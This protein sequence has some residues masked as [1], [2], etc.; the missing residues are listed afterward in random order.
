MPD[1][2][3]RLPRSSRIKQ[4]GDF[5]RAK[6]RGQRAVCGCLITNVLPRPEGAASRIG[7]VTS[8]KIGGAVVRSRARRLL[9]ETFRL[10]QHELPRPMD[11]ILVARLSIAGKSLAQVERDFLATLRQIT[12]THG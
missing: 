7:V 6:A 2:S 4:R 9:R 8:R 10:H 1:A 11:V 12:K 5:A 3:L